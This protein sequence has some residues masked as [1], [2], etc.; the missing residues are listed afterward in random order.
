[1]VINVTNIFLEMENKSLLGIEK[2]IIE[3]SLSGKVL[4]VF[5]F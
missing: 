1:M 3:Y 4:K 2:N 5:Y